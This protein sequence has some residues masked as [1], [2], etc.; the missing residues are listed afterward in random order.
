MYNI[1]L[2]VKFKHLV[3]HISIFPRQKPIRGE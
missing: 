3:H 1:E 2:N